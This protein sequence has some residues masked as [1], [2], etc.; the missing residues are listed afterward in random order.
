MVLFFEVMAEMW[1]IVK[2]PYVSCEANNPLDS[3]KSS[4]LPKCRVKQHQSCLIRGTLLLLCW[5]C[6]KLIS[7]ITQIQ[8][9]GE[10]R[11]SDSLFYLI[12]HSCWG[13]QVCPCGI[14][15][16]HLLLWGLTLTPGGPVSSA[17]TQGCSRNRRK[18]PWAA[19]AGKVCF[20][21]LFCIE[22]AITVSKVSWDIPSHCS[23]NI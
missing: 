6:P 3:R 21:H 13:T 12:R 1:C 19:G 4:I 14:L 11:W 17:V 2:C 10:K 15:A 16:S 20:L 22:R 5:N 23:L 18:G 9:P 8:N 7:S